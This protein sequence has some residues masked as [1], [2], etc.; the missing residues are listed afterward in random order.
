MVYSAAELLKLQVLAR[1]QR[2]PA[3]TLKRGSNLLPFLA[4]EY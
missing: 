1:R 4:G 2:E 3:I